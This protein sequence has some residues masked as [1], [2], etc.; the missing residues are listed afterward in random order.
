VGMPSTRGSSRAW[1]LRSSAS[2]NGRARPA[3][4]GL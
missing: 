4:V 3:S 2:R 1:R